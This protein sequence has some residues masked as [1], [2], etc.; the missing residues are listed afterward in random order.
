VQIFANVTN[1]GF[2]CAG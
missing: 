2:L 1:P